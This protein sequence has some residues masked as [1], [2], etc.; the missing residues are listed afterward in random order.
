MIPL[1]K[2]ISSSSN[3]IC[4]DLGFVNTSSKFSPGEPIFPLFFPIAFVV[5]IPASTVLSFLV[6]IPR[7]PFDEVT[8]LINSYLLIS[9]SLFLLG[10]P[11]PKRV[12]RFSNVQNTRSQ[13][14]FLSLSLHLSQS[15]TTRHASPFISVSPPLDYLILIP[16]SFPGSF[17]WLFTTFHDRPMLSLWSKLPRDALSDHKRARLT[18]PA[19]T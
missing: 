2:R 5:H 8:L 19:P 7:D 9:D 10:G 1:L 3:D 14:L 13:S 6:H 12:F 16:A 18:R 4:S 11:W 17:D 15:V